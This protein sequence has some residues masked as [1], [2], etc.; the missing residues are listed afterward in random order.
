MAKAASITLVG[1]EKPMAQAGRSSKSPVTS[2]R[3]MRDRDGSQFR[4]TAKW[5]RRTQSVARPGDGI[6][7]HTTEA[8]TVTVK[9]AKHQ[10]QP[11]S[12]R[13]SVVICV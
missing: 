13:L 3:L 5:P 10:Q 11:S 6:L 7:P 1:L 8:L 2:P 9:Q 4:R 12:Q